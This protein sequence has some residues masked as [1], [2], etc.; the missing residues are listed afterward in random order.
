M[1]NK[2]IQNEPEKKAAISETK[3]DTI[4]RILFYSR[5]I[6]ADFRRFLPLQDLTLVMFHSIVGKGSE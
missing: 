2:K 3:T 6:F 1:T 5:E 4:F